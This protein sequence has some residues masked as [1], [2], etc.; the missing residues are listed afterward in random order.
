MKQTDER[1]E[2]ERRRDKALRHGYPYYGVMVK[3]YK[4]TGPITFHP[5]YGSIQSGKFPP[6]CV[7]ACSASGSVDD[8]VEYWRSELNFEVPRELAIDYL[9]EFGAWDG[10]ELGAMTDEELAEKILWIA[11]CDISEQGE[12]LGLCH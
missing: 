3:G 5:K 8:A 11:C 6:D 7:A 4:Y 12:W 1:K 2:T 10:E 9:G